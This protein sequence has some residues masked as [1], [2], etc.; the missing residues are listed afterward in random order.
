M[1]SMQQQQNDA[2]SFLAG[3]AP[4]LIPWML[5]EHSNFHP[6]FADMTARLLRFGSLSEKQIAFANR[7]IDEQQEREQNG[8][9]TNREIQREAERALAQDCPSGR[10]QIEGEIIKIKQHESRYGFIWKMTVKDDRGFLV[11]STIPSF[12][13]GAH[14]PVLGYRGAQVGDRVKFAATI[15]PSERDPKF[16]FAKRPARC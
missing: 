12:L 3:A 11:W 4:E 8:G 6:I 13:E 5:T 15:T 10:A 7:L 16:G 14:D 2:R 9:R 1:K